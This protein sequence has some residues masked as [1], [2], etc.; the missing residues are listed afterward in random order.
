MV[1]ME[2]QKK[3]KKKLNCKFYFQTQ[4]KLCVSE[5]DKP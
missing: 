1:D 4:L 3:K 5:K 2:D